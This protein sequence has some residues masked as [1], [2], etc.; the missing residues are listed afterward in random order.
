MQSNQLSTL[1]SSK[2]NWWFSLS[3]RNFIWSK[4]SKLSLF[5]TLKQMLKVMK[6]HMRGRLNMNQHQ[7]VAWPSTRYVIR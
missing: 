6:H 5:R 3:L 2:Y 4:W 7:K 1:L